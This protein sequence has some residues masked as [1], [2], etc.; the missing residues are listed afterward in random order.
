VWQELAL[1]EKAGE[2]CNLQE[3]VVFNLV[4][5]VVMDGRKRP[6]IRYRADFVFDER[7]PGTDLWK[8][9]VADAKG[10]LTPT[11]RLKRHLMKA[12]EGVDIRLL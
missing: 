1:R 2:I 8:K 4:P 10:V 11:F 12:F 6:P 5:P 9:V 7:V 3:Q